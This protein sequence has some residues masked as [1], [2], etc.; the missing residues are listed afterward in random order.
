MDHQ[1]VYVGWRAAP[2]IWRSSLSLR[3]APSYTQ[4][5]M[6]RNDLRA[7]CKEPMP[8]FNAVARDAAAVL[9]AAGFLYI[10]YAAGTRCCSSR[11]MLTRWV[12][13]IAALLLIATALFHALAVLGLFSPIPAL[14]AIAVLAAVAYRVTGGAA[15]L[16]RELARDRLFIRRAAALFRR[17]PYRGGIVAFVVCAAPGLLRGLVLP[18]L[19]WDTLTYHGVKAGMWV[20]NGGVDTMVGTGPWGYYRNMLAGGE[21]FPAWAMLPLHSD[22]LAPAVDVIQWLALGL[23]LV[24]LARRLFIREPYASAAAGFVLAIPTVKLLVGSGYVESGL[25][26]ALAAGLT[27]GLVG[28]NARGGAAL[29]LGAGALGVAAATKFPMIPLSGAIAI[30]LVVRAV[31]AKRHAAAGA[32]VAAFAVAVAPWMF[33]TLWRTGLP[34]SPVP[35]KVAG[36]T[37]GEPS[38]ELKWYMDRP[39]L[40]PYA[41]ED[42]LAALKRVFS[43]PGTD[44]QALGLLAAVP[45]GLS[46]VGFRRLARRS[47]AGLVLIAVAIVVNLASYYAPEFS[48][49]RQYLVGR[50]LALPAADGQPAD[51]GQRLLVSSRFENRSNLFMVSSDRDLH[52]FAGVRGHRLLSGVGTSRLPPSP[53]RRCNGTRPVDDRSPR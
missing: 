49:V 14:V 19:G 1:N 33:Q 40:R 29:V 52:Q 32:A 4:S 24:V 30:V 8:L 41:F 7:R 28:W 34:F 17:S 27:L 39:A 26:L 42:E 15:W 3:F 43:R 20:Q 2:D 35:V 6:S 50:Q 25:L 44:T 36:I 48:M 31:T 16:R 21:V 45:L 23:V 37:L 38:L 46:F 53:P 22:A 11:G 47:R 9:M 13:V 5:R 51:A 12:G 10:A 18:P